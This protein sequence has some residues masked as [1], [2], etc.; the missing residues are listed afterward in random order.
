MDGI[1]AYGSKQIHSEADPTS[2]SFDDLTDLLY[3][4]VPQGSGGRNAG[5]MWV[6]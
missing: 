4:V 2:R 5:V 1:I 6:L 3:V